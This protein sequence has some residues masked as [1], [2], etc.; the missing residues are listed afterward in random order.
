MSLDTIENLRDIPIDYCVQNKMEGFKDIVNAVGGVT[1][2]NDLDFTTPDGSHFPKGE[3]KLNGERGLTYSRIR[4]EEP[5]GD[6]G[7]QMRQH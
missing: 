1:V 7:R 2:Q 4:H 5:R 3:F 6:Y